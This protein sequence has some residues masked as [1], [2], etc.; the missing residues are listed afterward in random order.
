MLLA[1]KIDTIKL[2]LIKGNGIALNGVESRIYED[3]FVLTFT[4]SPLTVSGEIYEL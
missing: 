1:C 3:F 4:L 2:F